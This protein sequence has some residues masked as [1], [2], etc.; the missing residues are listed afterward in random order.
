MSPF[1][2]FMYG[3][4]VPQEFLRRSL[5]AVVRVQSHYSPHGISDGHSGTATSFRSIALIRFVPVG[6]IP[7]VFHTDSFVCQRR[8]L[9]SAIDSFVKE[10]I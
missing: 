3:R 8:L 1:E 10:H 2:T 9:V 6:I 7:P 5:T 4:I